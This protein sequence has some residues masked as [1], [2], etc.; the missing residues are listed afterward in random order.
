M[1]EN[2]EASQPSLMDPKM[3]LTQIEEASDRLLTAVLATVRDFEQ[4]APG[5]A[6]TV[7]K[8]AQRMGFDLARFEGSMVAHAAF[9][10]ITKEALYLSG[11]SEINGRSLK[12]RK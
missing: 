5:D 10:A 8:T 6:I 12:R 9:I 11:Y 7:F 3:A 4:E 1:E 2:T